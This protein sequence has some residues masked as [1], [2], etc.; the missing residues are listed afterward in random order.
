MMFASDH[1]ASGLTPQVIE[2]ITGMT[3][4]NDH[5]GTMALL[6]KSIGDTKMAKVM[7]HIMGIHHL[8]GHM[9]SELITLRNKVLEHLLKQ[10]KSKLDADTYHQLH[11]SF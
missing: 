7:E 5:G 4:E 1:T 8:F 2:Q 10:A 9:P 3:D 6:A 11:M